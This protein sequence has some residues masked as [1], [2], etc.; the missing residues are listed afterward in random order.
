[1]KKQWTIV[2][3]LRPNGKKA[4][5]AA[6]ASAAIAPALSFL[7]PGLSISAQ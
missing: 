4:P 6:G 2:F 1:M 7:L 3:L 5:A